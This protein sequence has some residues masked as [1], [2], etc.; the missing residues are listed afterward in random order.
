MNEGRVFADT[1][2]L[3]RYFAED[4]I[5]RAVAAARLL[6]GGSTIV[7]STGVILEVLHV[8]RTEFGFQNPRLADLF[9]RLLTYA[10]VEL[11]DAE[12]AA[13]THAIAATRGMSARHISDAVLSAAAE[14]ARC[15]Y[16]ASFDE[17]LSSARVPVRLI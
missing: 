13:L 16:I 3:I 12:Q 7:I 9:V 10:P 4:D 8:L 1:S 2:V 17:K 15:N 14:S 11:A 6:E 5:P